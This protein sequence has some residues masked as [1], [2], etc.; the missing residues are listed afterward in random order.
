[1][2]SCVGCCIKAVI[3]T[4]ESETT[5]SLNKHTQTYTLTHSLTDNNTTFVRAS[6]ECEPTDRP[7][8]SAEWTII[9][10]IFRNCMLSIRKFWTHRTEHRKWKHR[11]IV[12]YHRA[13]NNVCAMLGCTFVHAYGSWRW[14]TDC[15]GR[16]W[17]RNQ[18]QRSLQ[19]DCEAVVCGDDQQAAAQGGQ[20]LRWFRLWVW[21]WDLGLDCAVYEL[22]TMGQ[23]GMHFYRDVFGCV[24]I[25]RRLPFSGCIFVSLSMVGMATRWAAQQRT[26]RRWKYFL[27]IRLRSLGVVVPP[28]V[29]S[30]AHHIVWLICCCVYDGVYTETFEGETYDYSYGYSIWRMDTYSPKTIV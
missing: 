21:R 15:G 25:V 10:N 5:Y 12:E 26:C 2:C 23:R 22:R 16:R 14:S 17:S 1:M 7:T 19:W 3:Y 20:I 24:W 28:F 6:F 30:F 4:I 27:F 29:S 18:L 9:N 8:D 13:D 11:I